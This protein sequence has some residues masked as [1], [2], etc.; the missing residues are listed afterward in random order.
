MTDAPVPPLDAAAHEA[1]VDRRLD[2]IFKPGDDYVCPGCGGLVCITF[3]VRQSND[4]T[5][6]LLVEPE[7]ATCKG[8]IEAWTRWADDQDFDGMAER[9]AAT[10]RGDVHLCHGC[11]QILHGWPA[12][13]VCDGCGDVLSPPPAGK[14]LRPSSLAD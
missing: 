3:D 12:G 13:G 14:P 8:F 6:Y 5:D 4:E 9:L 7:T 2:D 11:G 10:C 1:W